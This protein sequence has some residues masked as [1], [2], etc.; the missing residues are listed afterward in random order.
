MRVMSL[1]CCSTAISIA[2][3]G[4]YHPPVDYSGL[5]LLVGA[6]LASAFGG[7]IAQKRIEI[8]GTKTITEDNIK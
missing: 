6:F 1:L 7:K 3:I 5:S 8:N 2:I 4:L